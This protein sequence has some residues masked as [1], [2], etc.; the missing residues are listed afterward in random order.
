MR[1]RRKRKLIKLIQSHACPLMDS[2]FN[3]EHTLAVTGCSIVSN[4]KLLEITE[5]LSHYA[6]II[7]RNFEDNSTIQQQDWVKLIYDFY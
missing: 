3:Y 7:E 5:T 4:Q 1:T 2:Y 6:H